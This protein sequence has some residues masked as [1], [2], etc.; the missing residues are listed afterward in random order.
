MKNPSKPGVKPPTILVRAPN[1][2]GDQV[3]AFPFFHHLRKAYPKAHIAAVCVPW[4][5]NVQFKTLVDEVIVL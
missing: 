5:E 4:V 2:I 3:L 1:W